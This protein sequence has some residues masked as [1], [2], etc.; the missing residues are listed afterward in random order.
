MR[1]EPRQ[2]DLF[3]PPARQTADTSLEAYERIL[4]TLTERE[5]A[6]FIAVCDYLRETSFEDVTGL[7]LS[8]W[9]HSLVTSVRPRL[10]GLV[11]KGWL[12]SGS[13]RPSRARYEGHCHPVFPAVPRE[14]VER[15]RK[16]VSTS[17]AA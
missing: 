15:A 4:P 12:H 3:A 9:M 8:E 5:I 6:V 14:A 7:E 13:I 2:D 11:K 10:T 16:K 1:P 17:N